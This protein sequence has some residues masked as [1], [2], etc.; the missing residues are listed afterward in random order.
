VVGV[1]GADTYD[2]KGCSYPPYHMRLAL[3]AMAAA[4]APT[5]VDPN[6]TGKTFTKDGADPTQ[7]C[8]ID[9]TQGNFNAQALAD[10]ISDVRGKTLGCTFDLPKPASGE[11][12]KSRVNVQVTAGGVT[13][14]LLKRANEN[15]TCETDG[16]WDYDAEGRVQL[17]GKACADVKGAADAKVQIVVGCTTKVK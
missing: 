17:V 6:C 11:I 5:L 16:C 14:D 13:T 8:H 7:S 9:M 3:S 15:D 12:D 2:A 4:G 1:P 10:V